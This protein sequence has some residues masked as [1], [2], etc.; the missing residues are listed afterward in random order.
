MRGYSSQKRGES[1]P[2]PSPFRQCFPSAQASDNSSSMVARLVW[3][4]PSH[5]TLP[6][7]WICQSRSQSPVVA[8]SQYFHTI[9]HYAFFRLGENLHQPPKL[10]IY[11]QIHHRCSKE[12]GNRPSY[13]DQTTHWLKCMTWWTKSRLHNPVNT[14]CIGHPGQLDQTN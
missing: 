4:C 6:G 1:Q 11:S 12:R 7:V 10:L 9:G 8:A 14:I 3:S 13:S 5:A 2:H